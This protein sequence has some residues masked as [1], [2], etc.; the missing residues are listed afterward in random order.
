MASE[1]GITHFQYRYM[2]ADPNNCLVQAAEIYILTINRLN[3]EVLSDPAMKAVCLHELGHAL[4][5]SGHSPYSNDIM[6]P[7]LNFDQVLTNLTERDTATIK[8]LYQG[9]EHPH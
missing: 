1:Q 5:I 8:R 6:Y 4:G 7:T 2:R 3:G 9:Y